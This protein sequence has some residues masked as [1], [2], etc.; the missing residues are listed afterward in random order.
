MREDWDEYFMGIAWAASR[1]A[2]CDRL[3]V[4][5]V[6]VSVGSRSILATGY[7][8]S[9]RGAEHCDDVGHDMVNGHCVRTVHAEANAVAQ[10]AQ[11]GKSLGGCL[12]YVTAYPCWDCAKLMVNSGVFA[13][14][15][16]KAYRMDP[17]VADAFGGRIHPVA[18]PDPVAAHAEEIRRLRAEHAASL[19]RLTPFG[20][21]EEKKPC[22]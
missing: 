16:A 21:A 5:C 1:R 15:Y 18:V 3:H 9:V 11:L 7:N 17:R 22:A 19:A 6:M 20:G 12:A 14:R 4:G 8:G 10:A 13:V 2:T